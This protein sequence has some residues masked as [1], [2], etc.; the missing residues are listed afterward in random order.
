ML[1]QSSV[2]V[3]FSITQ[4]D[5]RG[6]S[7]FSWGVLVQW[8]KL[9]PLYLHWYSAFWRV[10]RTKLCQAAVSCRPVDHV[11]RGLDGQW[12]PVKCL[13]NAAFVSTYLDMFF[14]WL[15]GTIPY[16]WTQYCPCVY[17]NHSQWGWWAMYEHN[18]K[19]RNCLVLQLSWSCWWESHM[20]SIAFYFFTWTTVNL[21]CSLPSFSYHLPLL[22]FAGECWYKR[23]IIY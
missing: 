8:Q 19:G 16:L 12:Q 5:W 4:N 3:T 11:C 17:V 14:E 9:P 10:L 13:S 6:F 18:C 2:K 23:H 1:R 7:R 15:E 20:A 22:L 21:L